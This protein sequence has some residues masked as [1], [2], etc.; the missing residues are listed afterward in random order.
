M[1][2]RIKLGWFN[3]WVG[4]VWVLLLIPTSLYFLNQS[5]YLNYSFCITDVSSFAIEVQADSSQLIITTDKGRFHYYDKSNYCLIEKALANAK[6]IKIWFEDKNNANNLANIIVDN[7]IV[8]RRSNVE[9]I[10][11]L[12]GL[13]LSFIATISSIYLIFRTKGWGSYD[14]MR[15]HKPPR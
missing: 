3:A 7:K 12:I 8:I 14:L 13:V 1:N 9:I 2:D 11:F 10:F 5:A 4:L 15:K 6:S